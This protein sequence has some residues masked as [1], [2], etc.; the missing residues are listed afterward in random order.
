[1]SNLLKKK[2][3]LLIIGKNKDWKHESNIGSKNNRRSYN[4][5]H[6][7]LIELLKYKCLLNN[8]LLIEQEESYTS[9]TSFACNEKLK[10]YGKENKT[11]GNQSQSIFKPKTSSVREGQKLY[12]INKGNKFLL[13]HAD[14]NGA[15]NIAR[16]VIP[17][18]NIET[19]KTSDKTSKIKQ[20]YNYR[21][22]ALSN[23]SVKGSLFVELNP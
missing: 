5:P 2:I 22:V 9:K 13:C 19:I 1:M 18:F 8:I 10:E 17:A 16:K 6:S 20:I 23:Y 15:M 3:N 11:E 14:V 21:I 12:S 4:L 7:K